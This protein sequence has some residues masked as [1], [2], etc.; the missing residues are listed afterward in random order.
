MSFFVYYIQRL[1][2]ILIKPTLVLNKC[3]KYLTPGK[4]HLSNNYTVISKNKQKKFNTFSSFGKRGKIKTILFNFLSNRK[5]SIKNKNVLF[6]G[7]TIIISTS[8]KQCKI[9]DSYNN[10]ILTKYFSKKIFRKAMKNYE[11]LKGIYN[12]IEIKTINYREQYTIENFIDSIS[13]TSDKILEEMFNLYISNHNKFEKKNID[14]KNNSVHFSNDKKFKTIY[15]E[16]NSNNIYIKCH[17]DFWKSNIIFDGNKYNIID[18]E[19]VNY[20]PF[21]YDIFYFI[22]TESY[23]LNN[24]ALLNQYLCGNYDNKM[25]VLFDKYNS[26]FDANKRKE[27]ILSFLYEYVNDR[28]KKMLPYE[29]KKEKKKFNIFVSKIVEDINE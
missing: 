16:I 18:F 29:I 24:D 21:Y 27:Y 19:N 15:Y 28:W 26:C 7:D 25:S 20:F 9:I 3:K 14:V 10:L 2:F 11:C 13:I 5:F 6:N 8:G 1:Y 12:V 23:I 17:G 4:Y 22:F